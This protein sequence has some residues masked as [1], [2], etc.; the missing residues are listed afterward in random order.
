[1]PLGASPP[2]LS[3]KVQDADSLSL[4][5]CRDSVPGSWESAASSM[6]NGIDGAERARR[7]TVRQLRLILGSLP[8]GCSPRERCCGSAEASWPASKQRQCRGVSVSSPRLVSRAV[9]CCGSQRRAPVS[10]GSK[11]V[12]LDGSLAMAGGYK[13]TRAVFWLVVF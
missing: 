1:M 8:C 4:L 9:C 5:R 7:P 6:T 3:K 2:A 10:T 12:L 13:L 11:E